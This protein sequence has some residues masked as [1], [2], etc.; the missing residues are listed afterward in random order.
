MSEC[1]LRPLQVQPRQCLKDGTPNLTY[2]R[3]ACRCCNAAKA[4][5]LQFLQARAHQLEEFQRKQISLYAASAGQLEV[6]QWLH[7]QGVAPS[8][9]TCKK[10]AAGG[11]LVVLQ[12]AQEQGCDWDSSTCA[13]AA[14]GGHLEVLQYAH[15]N[16]CEWG[17]WTGKAAAERGHL[18]VLQYT[19]QNGCAWD[20]GTC[21]AAAGGGHLEVLQFARQSGCEWGAHVCS[22]AAAH[23]NL[24][25]L[26]WLRE[27]GCP[28][29][30]CTSLEAAMYNRLEMLKWSRQQQAP[31]PWWSH[32]YFPMNGHNICPSVL[33]FLRQQQAPLSA[34]HSAQASAAATETTCAFLSLRA[35]LHD[36]TPNE[37]VLTIV[38]LAFLRAAVV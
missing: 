28:W 25:I 9:E 27:H 12:W 8:C 1:W 14:R 6:L 11:H 29:N 24:S 33:V 20:S 15:Q 31:C 7:L 35:A 4:G 10:A 13:A 36:R 2:F 16:G 17:P 3:S 34:S 32:A 30:S 37:V 19:R 23:G 5:D 26:K 18:A 22:A 21:E 38:T